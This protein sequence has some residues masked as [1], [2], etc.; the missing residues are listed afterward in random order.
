MEDSKSSKSSTTK[1]DA[2]SV[3][4]FQRVDSTNFLLTISSIAFFGGLTS[5]LILARRKGGSIAPNEIRTEMWLKAAELKAAYKGQNASGERTMQI[6][7][8][9]R[10]SSKSQE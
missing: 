6:Q 9:S 5:A 3:P 8:L 10:R 7:A 4:F 2:K 1:T